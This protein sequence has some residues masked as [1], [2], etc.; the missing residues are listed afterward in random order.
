[1]FPYGPR[2]RRTIQTHMDLR[3]E[4]GVEMGMGLR[5]TNVIAENANDK[6]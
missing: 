6:N 4:V 2:I 3:T 1:M 5:Y